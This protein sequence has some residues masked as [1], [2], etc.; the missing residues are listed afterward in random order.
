MTHLVL[1][2]SLLKSLQDKVVVFTGG[3]TGIGRE[4][5]KIFIGTLPTS[6]HEPK[7]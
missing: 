2:N 1:N 7:S 4:A 3:S 6:C 5:V